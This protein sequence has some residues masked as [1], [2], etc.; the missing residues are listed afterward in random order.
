MII[1]GVEHL[2][3]GKPFRLW[4]YDVTEAKRQAAI[5]A[6][7]QPVGMREF[8]AIIEARGPGCLRGVVLAKGWP[9]ARSTGG[10]KH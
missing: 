9:R 3:C 2:T 8:R 4:H 7:A 1:S 6:G 5:Q 10:N